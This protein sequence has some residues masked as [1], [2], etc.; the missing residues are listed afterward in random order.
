MRLQRVGKVVL[1][2]EVK[3]LMQAQLLVVHLDVRFVIAAHHA[4]RRPRLA[5]HLIRRHALL[6]GAN[7]HAQPDIQGRVFRVQPGLEALQKRRIVLQMLAEDVEGVAF[8]AADDGAR[9]RR[10]SLHLAGKGAQHLVA[11]GAPV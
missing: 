9:L 8:R 4:A 1:Q 10:E 7:A 3:F 6:P 2:A 5:E 11:E